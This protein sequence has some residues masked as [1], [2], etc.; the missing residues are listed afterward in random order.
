MCNVSPV[1]TNSRVV[2]DDVISWKYWQSA[3]MRYGYILSKNF[4]G[5]ERDFLKC[6]FPNFSPWWHKNSDY[7]VL[8]KIVICLEN[9][10][11]CE[12]ETLDTH[13]PT[14]HMQQQ[15]A[16][17]RKLGPDLVLVLT[18]CWQWTQVRSTGPSL[19]SVGTTS[20][21]ATGGGALWTGPIS[22]RERI[23]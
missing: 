10:P 23:F 17:A 7:Y 9:I 20:W 11:V 13:T 4:E 6:F 19:S 18:W 3:R 2:Q 16:Q 14:R 8:R 12:D 15:R 22:V 1:R 21:V 5:K